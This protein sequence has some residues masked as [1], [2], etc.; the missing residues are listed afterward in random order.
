MRSARLLPDY[1]FTQRQQQQQQQ[2]QGK[3]LVSRQACQSNAEFKDAYGRFLLSAFR[4][5]ESTSK[6]SV[7]T[8]V[9]PRRDR[10]T[11]HDPRVRLHTERTATTTTTTTKTTTTRTTTV[12]PSRQ[13]NSSAFAFPRSRG[14]VV[15][16]T[17]VG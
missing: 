1:P 5:G 2:Q 11:V 13:R 17:G 4:A 10:P 7:T 6:S 8:G 14:A 16:S 12:R 9:V 3:K 15:R